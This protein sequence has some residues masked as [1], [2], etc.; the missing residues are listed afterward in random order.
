MQSGVTST[1]VDRTAKRIGISE[2]EVER[3]GLKYELGAPVTGAATVGDAVAVG[4]GDGSL[5]FFS[6]RA[7]TLRSAK[8]SWSYLVHGCLPGCFS[9]RW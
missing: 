1:T 7:K 6:L 5:R 2:T 9:D 8:P 4:F 3:R